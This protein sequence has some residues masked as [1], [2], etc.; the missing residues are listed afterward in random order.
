LVGFRVLDSTPVPFTVVVVPPVILIDDD[1]FFSGE[2]VTFEI[3][4][5][6]VDT[7]VVEVML[8]V[9][10]DCIKDGATVDVSF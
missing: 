1:S 10:V 9:S 4:V 6:V 2:S 5:V 8:G 3:M 7:V